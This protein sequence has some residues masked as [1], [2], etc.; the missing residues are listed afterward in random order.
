M[1]AIIVTTQFVNNYGAV[2]Q[3]YGFHV[4]LKEHGWEHVF[5]DQV[6]K[7]NRVFE[8]ILPLEKNSLYRIYKNF[9][10]IPFAAQLHRRNARFLQFVNHNFPLSPKYKDQQAFLQEAN[11]YDLYITGGDQLWNRSC[12][13]RPVNLLRFGDFSKPRI[14]YSTSLGSAV[15]TPEEKAKLYAYLQEYAEISVREKEACELLNSEL[16]VN[17][18]QNI[19]GCFLVDRDTW[20][21]VEVFNRKMPDKFILVYE[22]LDHPDLNKA[23]RAM[24]ERYSLPVVLIAQGLN[25]STDCDIKVLDAGPAE[26]LGLFS[27]AKA[28]V[29]TSFHGTCFCVINEKPFVSLIGENETRINAVLDMFGLQQCYARSFKQLPGSPIDF[30]S[31]REKILQSR[32][33]AY[34]YLEK[35]FE[36]K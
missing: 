10:K 14:S 5:Y 27:H 12:L 4:F 16:N 29:T 32:I 23:I 9:C 36:K 17:V 19:D 20:K 22:L 2:L 30:R 25:P 26:F 33:Q 1:K 18:R 24:R 31:A 35:Y 21:N 7:S 28:V 3:A 15:Y 11:L 13:A 6:S 34:Q 8:S